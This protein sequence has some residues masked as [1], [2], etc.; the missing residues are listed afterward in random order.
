MKTFI[1]TVVI[2]DFVIPANILEKR[3][4]PTWTEPYSSFFYEYVAKGYYTETP[5]P[6]DYRIEF[7]NGTHALGYYWG[8]ESFV[9]KCLEYIE[10]KKALPEQS[11]VISLTCVTCGDDE[12]PTQ[13]NP[14]VANYSLAD[15]PT[16]VYTSPA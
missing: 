14:N 3:W 9:P 10:A 15:N 11:Y 12:H 4:W 7:L 2:P 1:Q 5:H 16:F 6:Q 13:I 8:D